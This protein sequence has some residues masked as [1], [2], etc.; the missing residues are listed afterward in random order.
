MLEVV[1]SPVRAAGLMNLKVELTEVVDDFL[2]K[3]IPLD[4]LDLLLFKFHAPLDLL[5]LGRFLRDSECGS[6]G[7]ED[8]T[9]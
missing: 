7:A 5:E 8:L 9:Y 1:P 3:D 4:F 2:A 6:G